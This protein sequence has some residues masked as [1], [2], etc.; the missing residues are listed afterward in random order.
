MTDIIS[1]HAKNLKKHLPDFIKK[2][3]VGPYSLSQMQELAAVVH[4]FPSFHAASRLKLVN[5][6]AKLVPDVPVRS[7][8]VY[9]ASLVKLRP[10]HGSDDKDEAVFVFPSMNEVAVFDIRDKHADWFTFA[11]EAGLDPSEYQKAAAEFWSDYARFPGDMSLYN[12]VLYLEMKARNL[13]EAAFGYANV[14][15]SLDAIIQKAGCKRVPYSIP[16]NRGYHVL[17]EG[18]VAVLTEQ[19]LWAQ[20]TMVCNKMLQLNENDNI[21]FRFYKKEIESKRGL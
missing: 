1:K 4:G 19:G 17:N 12:N 13:R 7:I 11:E 16:S 8:P 6:E 18:Y 21:G 3:G 5:T 10:W 14:I 20:A 15:E 2:H 9:D